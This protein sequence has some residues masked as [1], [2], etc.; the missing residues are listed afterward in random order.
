MYSFF[1]L[2]QV[3]GTDIVISFGMWLQV[4]VAGLL[5]YGAYKWRKHQDAGTTPSSLLPP[6]IGD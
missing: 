3:P 6:T 1:I 4:L 2:G 5:A